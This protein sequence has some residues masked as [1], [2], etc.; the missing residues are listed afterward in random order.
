MKA[1]ERLVPSETLLVVVDVQERLARV[2]DPDAIALLL[3]SARILIESARV[4]GASV[5]YTEQYP[6]GLG[7]T[8]P[9]LVE[10]LARA[11]AR[12]LPSGTGSWHSGSGGRRS[13][14]GSGAR[15]PAGSSNTSTPGG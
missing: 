10:L 3:R 15:E 6:K 12:R 14:C 5:A 2:M 9:E 11:G 13:C 1:L 4:L 7:P 8:L